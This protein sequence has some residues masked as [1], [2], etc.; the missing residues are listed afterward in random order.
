MKRFRGR[1]R[2][3]AGLDRPPH[4]RGAEG[5]VFVGAQASDV[6]PEE[7]GLTA[8]RGEPAPRRIHVPPGAMSG[9][10]TPAAVRRRRFRGGGSEVDPRRDRGRRAARHLRTP[11]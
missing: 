6:A 10:S 4:L 2:G 11:E 3:A 9:P 8:A 7:A 1:A 5:A